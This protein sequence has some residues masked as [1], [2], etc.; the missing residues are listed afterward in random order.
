M[1]VIVI[2]RQD[3]RGRMSV[4]RDQRGCAKWTARTTAENEASRM[5]FR[6]DGCAFTVIEGLFDSPEQAGTYCALLNAGH[7]IEHAFRQAKAAAK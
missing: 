4:A 7:S 2:L 6:E 3:A 5:R 1:A